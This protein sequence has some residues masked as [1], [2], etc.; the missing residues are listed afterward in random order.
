MLNLK[1]FVAIHASFLPTPSREQASQTSMPS[2]ASSNKQGA[3][4]LSLEELFQRFPGLAATIAGFLDQDSKKSLRMC[5]RDCKAAVNP[6]LT[7]VR[8]R[9]RVD[10]RRSLTLLQSPNWRHLQGLSMT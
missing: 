1:R 6:V 9:G 8:L 10:T 7:C 2:G 5:S 4:C 3:R